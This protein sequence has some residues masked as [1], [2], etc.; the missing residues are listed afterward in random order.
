MADASEKFQQLLRELFQFDRADLDF[1]IYRIINYKREVIERFI[2]E[3]LPSAIAS[4]LDSGSLADQAQIDEEMAEVDQQFKEMAQQ[5]KEM[6]D[7]GVLGS[8]EHPTLPLYYGTPLEKR[9][10]SLKKRY[11]SLEKKAAFSRTAVEVSIYNHLYAFFSRYYQAGD[12]VFKRRYYQA[13]DFVSKHRYSKR[14]HYAVPYHGG[15]VYLHWANSDQYY[16]K[17]AEHFRDYDW[18]GAGGVV[19]HFWLRAAAVEQNNVKGA[20]RF[21]L[22]HVRGIKWQAKDRIV[23]IPFAYR[24]LTAAESKQYGNREQQDKIIAA[25]VAAIPQQLSGAPDALAALTGER[26]C[27]GKGESVSHLE[28]HLRQYTRRNTSEFF[29]HQDL[30]AFLSCELDFYLKSEVLNLDE[31]AAADENIAASWCQMVRITKAAGKLV[32]EFLAEMENFQKKLWEKRKFVTETHYCIALGSIGSGFYPDILAN[33]AQW[34]EWQALFDVGGAER[35]PAFL[36][37][38]P[39]LVLDTKHFDAGFTDRLLAS[40]DDLDGLTDGLLV[41]SENWQALNLL[42]W[43][44]PEVKCIYIDPPCNTGNDGFIHRDPYQ[45]SNWLYML[46]SRLRLLRELL[47]D[48]GVIFISIDDTEQH[49]LRMLMD[50]VFGAENFVSNIIWQKKYAPAN[51]AKYFLA[52]HGFVLCYAKNRINGKGNPFIAWQHRFLPRAAKQDRL[53]KYLYKYD[54]NDGRGPWRPEDLSVETYSPEY[55]Y[56]IAALYNPPNGRCWSVNKEQ[57]QIWLDENRISLGQDGKSSPQL[58]RYLREVKQGI[59]PL[60][61]WLHDEVG[62]TDGARKVSK[63]IFSGQQLLSDN[64]KA[65]GLLQRICTIAGDQEV[66]ILD[67]F[68]GSGSTGHAVINSNREDGGQR[69]FILVE[70]GEY[71]DI[72]LLPR[73]KKVAFAPEWKDGKPKRKATPEEAERSPRIVKYIRLESYEDA[74]D[75]IELDET[76]QSMKRYEEAF[77]DYYKIEYMLEREASDNKTLLNVEKLRS[78]FC[79]RVRFRADGQTRE[80]PVD[81]PETFNYLLGL[82]VQTRRVYADGERHYLV[83]RGETRDAPGQEVAII[84]RATDGW[85]QADFERDR[86][87]VAEHK[88]AAGVAVVY[89]NGDS[90]IPHATAIEPLFKERI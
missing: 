27:N 15:E 67:S 76:V 60:T 86:Q 21:F 39:T 64:P 84:W 28:H 33:D 48:D 80:R 13:G 90:H 31:M 49:H 5:L 52:D 72:V 8:L 58:K 79:Y 55:D 12:F 56:P 23:S 24:P 16:I 83:Y 81:L 45:H 43:Y 71:F 18:K 59:V 17:T 63:E 1:G 41:H 19:V 34:G 62:H 10:I 51:D 82:K 44:Q 68:A 73:I 14:Q 37:R 70:M 3:K 11:I 54:D 88:L 61:I 6:L 66:L 26:Q 42:K 85:T 4:A 69:K 50:E 78:P 2:A 74:L 53:N 35:S 89:V 38:Q 36:Q 9:Y 46:W 20:K 57:M 25:A 77:G 65:L 47:A 40:F 30:A 32:I 75:S 22:P 7:E 29:I 87:F